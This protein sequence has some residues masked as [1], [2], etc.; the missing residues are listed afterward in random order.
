MK[1]TNN[2][3]KFF[4][5]ALLLT[6][7]VVMSGSLQAQSGEG[8]ITYVGGLNGG[9][10]IDP[11]GGTSGANIS[12]SKS[13]TPLN[14]NDE[15]TIKFSFPAGDFKV[16][17]DLVLV[18]AGTDSFVSLAENTQAFLNDLANDLASRSNVQLNVGAVSYGTISYE[19]F[20]APSGLVGTTFN[21]CVR[22]GFV[23][24]LCAAAISQVPVEYRPMIN[25]LAANPGYPGNMAGPHSEQFRY[26]LGDNTGLKQLTDATSS[27]DPTSAT[28][29]YNTMMTNGSQ[30]AMT[31]LM[32]YCNITNCSMKSA[33][34]YNMTNTVIGTNLEAGIKA[35]KEMLAQGSAPAENKFLVIVADG[36]TYYWDS[37]SATTSS[38]QQ[39]VSQGVFTSAPSWGQAGWDWTRA[40][41]EFRK[42]PDFESFMEN[43]GVLNDTTSQLK[44]ADFQAWQNNPSSIDLTYLASSRTDYP[45]I[46]L[47]KGM[48]HAGSQL[49]S[50]VD[51]QEG[52]LNILASLYN[53]NDYP[54][55]T[56]P[57]GN[58]YDLSEMFRDYTEGISDA[59]YFINNAT[60]S[61]DIADSFDSIVDQL[62]YLV[63]QGKLTDVIGNSFDLVM[64]GSALSA[65]DIRI[66]LDGVTLTGV[67]DS[68]NPNQINFGTANSSGVYPY[69]ITYTPGVGEKIELDINVPIETVK[70]LELDYTIKLTRSEIPGWNDVKL[71]ESAEISFTNSAG[72]QSSAIFPVP[73]TKYYVVEDDDKVTEEDVKEKEDS[74]KDIPETGNELLNVALI[75]LASSASLATVARIRNN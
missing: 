30:Y 26:L 3:L 36:G 62:F 67:I 37:S 32:A 9:P 18:A 44:V 55:Y 28:A 46:S 73:M 71:N 58:I 23:G 4:G 47:E 12:G 70:K 54:P 52:R 68:S 25:N 40:S 21:S 22:S 50:Y 35:G 69:V 65:D 38:A 51:N 24:P 1:K 75:L 10:N 45:F 31:S 2:I 27:T 20:S 41:A 59:Y 8:E 42:Y 61:Q 60:Q 48:A 16:E 56:A 15:S 29:L 49:K 43:S 72:T 13:A 33:L 6:F 17:Y 39:S 19:T 5:L 14:A 63:A 57:G 7:F 64:Q 11:F 34:G 53:Y 66:T 74:I